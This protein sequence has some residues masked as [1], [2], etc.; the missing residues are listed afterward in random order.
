MSSELYDLPTN[1]FLFL[2]LQDFS[3]TA[4]CSA[5]E[6]LILAN[7][8]TRNQIY[9]WTICTSDGKPVHSS[10]GLKLDPDSSIKNAA[11]FSICFICGGE[12]TEIGQY[13]SLLNKIKESYSESGVVLGGVHSGSSL[14]ASGG[15]LDGYGGVVGD[16][17]TL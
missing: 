7:K 16:L 4:L 10:N 9:R 8:A 14:L 17:Y 13:K 12:R 6:P 11:D 15:L 1:K 5:I 3:M 2:L